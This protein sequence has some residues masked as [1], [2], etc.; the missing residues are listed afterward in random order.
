MGQPYIIASRAFLKGPIPSIVH[1]PGDNAK[2]SFQF[3][4][5]LP[6]IS[7]M[8]AFGYRASGSVVKGR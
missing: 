2:R 3:T 5:Y 8:V 4:R 1:A 7:L 6:G